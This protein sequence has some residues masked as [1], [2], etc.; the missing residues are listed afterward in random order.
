MGLSRAGETSRNLTFLGGTWARGL[1]PFCQLLGDCNDG[2][3]GRC[4]EFFD[5][6]G[7]VLLCWGTR[8]SGVV[9]MDS[10]IVEVLPRLPLDIPLDILS[11]ELGGTFDGIK[12]FDTTSV[13]VR[14]GEGFLGDRFVVGDVKPLGF[15]M[16]PDYLIC[17]LG[18]ENSPSLGFCAEIT[19][20]LHRDSH[21]LLGS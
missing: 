11:L 4:E 3:M 7:V 20:N 1:F 12:I 18:T 2:L 19:S 13:G 14:Y 5:S 15:G 8:G 17:P 16:G 9:E 21:S 6:K 10:P